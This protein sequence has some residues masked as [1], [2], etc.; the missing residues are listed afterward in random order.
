V[1]SDGKPERALQLTPPPPEFH[2]S[3][4]SK[5]EVLQRAVSIDPPYLSVSSTL[6]SAGV[7][8]C[9]IR[10]RPHVPIKDLSVIC[11]PEHA[12]MDFNPVLG[13][14]LTHTHCIQLKFPQPATA[15]VT[16]F[17]A[18]IGAATL[19]GSELP[20]LP[21]PIALRWIDPI[22]LSP[23]VLFLG[24]I[25]VGEPTRNRITLTAIGGTPFKL[26]A[27]VAPKELDTITVI[28]PGSPTA[29]TMQILDVVICAHVPGFVRGMLILNIL[30][31]GAKVERE[32]LFPFSYHGF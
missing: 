1:S 22:Q 31:S 5:N 13:T 15:R 23:P 14:S 11:P 26:N 18:L 30:E 27:V 4:P 20:R 21:L 12:L 25:N 16:S 19:E 10:I 28:H 9:L 7:T 8:E 3:E 6:G 29:S 32:L 24:G 2:T 17:E